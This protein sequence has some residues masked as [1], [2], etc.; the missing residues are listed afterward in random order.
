[1]APSRRRE[2][3]PCLIVRDANE[4]ALAFVYCEDEPGRRPAAKLLTRDEARR[5]A[6]NVAQAAGAPGRASSPETEPHVAL[7]TAHRMLAWYR[8]WFRTEGTL[9]VAAYAK[10]LVAAHAFFAGLLFLGFWLFVLM[11]TV[12]ITLQGP[13]WTVPLPTLIV[14]PLWLLGWISWL[15]I[16]VAST[17]RFA[18]HC[19]PPDGRSRVARRV[20]MK[21]VSTNR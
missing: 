19:P 8:S 9:D 10:H 5:I 14:F 15:S 7:R 11:A 4:Q 18:R 21:S 20:A 13:S 6:V 3:A 1:M 12:L 2:T 17:I 16:L